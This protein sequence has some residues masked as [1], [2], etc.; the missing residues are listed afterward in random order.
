MN[1]I[2]CRL[3]RQDDEDEVL[4]LVRASLGATE[5]LPQTSETWRWKHFENPFGES[6]MVVAELDSRIAGVRPYLRWHLLTTE[7]RRLE[8]LRAVDTATHP[9]FRRRGVFRAM[10]TEANRLAQ[11]ANFDLVFNTPNDASRPGYLSMGWVTV[12]K[13][14]LHA[15][16]RRPWAFFRRGVSGQVPSPDAVLEH[17]VAWTAREEFMDREPL[18]LRTE[19]TPAYMH[20]RFARHPTVPYLAPVGTSSVVVRPNIRNGRTEIVVS[21]LLRAEQDEL[22]SLIQTNRADYLVASFR[23]GS[24]EERLIRNRR[25]FPVPRL[26][27]TLVTLPLSSRASSATEMASWDLSL[28]DLELM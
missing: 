16:L 13:P 27:L 8:A 19:R 18:G 28:G 24:P 1:E 21:E 23:P 9:E 15:R 4:Q 7:G 3:Y 26:G 2:R 17:A 5:V 14:R 12:G 6:L 10:T 20:W 22:I 25:F 11:E